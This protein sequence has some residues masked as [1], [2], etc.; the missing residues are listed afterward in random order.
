MRVRFPFLPHSPI[1][2]L[3]VRGLDSART[4]PVSREK[5]Y[6]YQLRAFADVV[7]GIKA[8]ITGGNDAI[9]NMTTIDAIYRAA[10]FAVR[11]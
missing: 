2:R 1:C 8:P 6:T 7:A 5:T 9:A 10:G 4:E 3:E 11:Q